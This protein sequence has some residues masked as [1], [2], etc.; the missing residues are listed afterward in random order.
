MRPSAK[1][2]LLCG[3]RSPMKNGRQP[4]GAA[5]TSAPFRPVA[6]C[7]WSFRFI[8][9]RFM[10]PGTKGGVCRIL[11]RSLW[12]LA[13]VRTHKHLSTSMSAEDLWASRA[14]RRHQMTSCDRRPEQQDPGNDSHQGPP[15][16]DEEI[17]LRTVQALGSTPSGEEVPTGE[18][19]YVY[20][21]TF[22]NLF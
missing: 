20:V 8:V 18:C 1:R 7:P 19:M 17:W 11:F 22:V 16:F 21:G 4:T 15:R 14:F 13:T 12:K 9:R 6:G 5:M 3:S 10:G 2:S